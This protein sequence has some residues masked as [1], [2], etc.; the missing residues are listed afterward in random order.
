MKVKLSQVRALFLAL[1]VET[2][3]TWGPKQAADRV[4]AIAKY[5]QAVDDVKD[6]ALLALY[7]Q[8]ATA[9]TN[10]D[11]IEVEDD[12]PAAEPPSAKKPAAK[13]SAQAG[14]VATNGDG[15]TYPYRPGVKGSWA[16]AKEYWKKHPKSI[17]GRG[18][19]VLRTIYEELMAAGKGANPVGVTKEA[20]VG[21]LTQKHGDRDPLKMRAYMNNMVPT[22]LRDEYGIHVQRVKN[23][24]G[25]FAYWIKGDGKSAPAA[26]AD[27]PAKAGK[28]SGKKKSKKAA[29]TA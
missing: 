5:Q 13:K 8:L 28:K 29:A 7:D 20:L 16:K 21:V 1:G 26:S 6:P 12:G 4:K 25:L 2:T 24:K 14:K 10:G 9:V 15:P 17:T 11:P 27:R 22:G 19:G 3:D 18:P 23:D